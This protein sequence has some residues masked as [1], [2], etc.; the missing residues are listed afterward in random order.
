MLLVISYNVAEE[1]QNDFKI[2]E[3][4]NGQLVLRVIEL[5]TRL[6]DSISTGQTNLA[7][8]QAAYTGSR[9]Y[10]QDVPKNTL[11]HK[12]FDFENQYSSSKRP[13][14]PGEKTEVTSSSLKSKIDYAEGIQVISEDQ[15][16]E[17]RDSEDDVSFGDKESWRQGVNSK[18]DSA[19]L[20]QMNAM[21]FRETH[22]IL[23]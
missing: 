18:F 3:D 5:R 7:I 1:N 6:A 16:G 2:A 22:Y 17:R 14:Y 10:E 9:I 15:V 4:N 8:P 13:V 19:L 11:L 12:F 20:S 21:S 23:K